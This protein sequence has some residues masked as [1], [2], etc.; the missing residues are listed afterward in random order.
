MFQ[1][2]DQKKLR[3]SKRDSNKNYDAVGEVYEEDC[4]HPIMKIVN[5]D[6][7]N[8]VET[9]DTMGNV[10]IIHPNDRR[11][12]KTVKQCAEIFEH[13][14]LFEQIIVR[15]KKGKLKTEIRERGNENDE[16]LELNKSQIFALCPYVWSFFT[17]C[18]SAREL[19]LHVFGSSIYLRYDKRKEWL[20]CF[21]LNSP[22]L[23]LYSIDTD[24][25]CE[26]EARFICV[27][28]NTIELL[29]LKQDEKEIKREKYLQ[30]PGRAIRTKLSDQTWGNSK[31]L[32]M[33][34]SKEEQ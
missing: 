28:E 5:H 25:N 9:L 19:M 26:S 18:V 3:F 34:H 21:T 1:S 13:Y 2:K 14:R 6:D 22:I 30:L 31:L 7:D 10:A 4:A 11:L 27:T 24:E 29:S 16:W 33:T 17:H 12:D 15:D 32:I 20:Q 8:W 23:T